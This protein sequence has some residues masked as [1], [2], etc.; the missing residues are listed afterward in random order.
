MCDKNKKEEKDMDVKNLNLD[1]IGLDFGVGQPQKNEA[2]EVI[3]K[4]ITKDVKERSEL[5]KGE[6]RALTFLHVIAK[7]LDWEFTKNFCDHYLHLMRSYQRK[8]IGEDI[9]LLTGFVAQAEMAMRPLGYPIPQQGFPPAA[10][11]PPVVET[12]R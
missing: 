8:G 1:G 3:K 10:M 6:I 5:N 11:N 12:R 7:E 2:F 9:Q 4:Y